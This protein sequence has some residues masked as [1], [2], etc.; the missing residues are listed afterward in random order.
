MA[1]PNPSHLTGLWLSRCSLPSKYC[2]RYWEAGFP[3]NM[4]TLR[5]C[6]D[7][8]VGICLA[9]AWRVRN[10]WWYRCWCF[11][12]FNV[13]F[14]W[15]DSISGVT[16]QFCLQDIKTFATGEDQDHPKEE[17]C[18][19]KP[20]LWTCNIPLWTFKRLTSNFQKMNLFRLEKYQ[21]W[22]LC[23]Q[24]FFSILLMVQK[25]NHPTT[26]HVLKPCNLMG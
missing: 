24:L 15:L 26:Q 6:N 21:A 5:S 19:L 25:W 20:P 22:I 16:Q 23:G 4:G 12:S 11:F 9:R 18:F 3:E 7:A 1:T 2:H 10:W 14:A 8:C 13:L 17:C